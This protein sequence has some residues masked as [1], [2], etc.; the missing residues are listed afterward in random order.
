MANKKSKSVNRRLFGSI[1]NPVDPTIEKGKALAESSHE[2]NSF[3][4]ER[5]SA[6]GYLQKLS[7]KNK[8]Q[9]RFFIL[10]G[11]FLMYWANK[12][13]SEPQQTRRNTDACSTPETVIDLRCIV[14]FEL[15]ENE[16]V[17]VLSSE[18]KT[19]RLTGVAQADMKHMPMWLK[20]CERAKEKAEQAVQTKSKRA[21]VTDFVD[22]SNSLPDS[23]E[24]VT[25]EASLGNEFEI[26]TTIINDTS[27]TEKKLSP[28]NVKEISPDP[29]AESIGM[30]NE[31]PI[32]QLFHPA[33]M[34][35]PAPP[36]EKRPPSN[37]TPVCG[38]FF[39]NCK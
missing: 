32:P 20:A 26:N 9:K 23:T 30:D 8:W 5:F 28:E 17:L 36:S 6:R 37:K 13:N 15:E 25:E 22:N 35:P 34:L 11:P 7:H 29:I 18:S 21:T 38:F 2:V 31:A 33:T 10:K 14:A 12:S 4:E 16:S 27:S 39:G 24:I 3:L 19:I 1:S